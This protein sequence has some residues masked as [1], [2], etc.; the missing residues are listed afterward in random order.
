MS[1]AERYEGTKLCLCDERTERLWISVDAEIKDGKL[2]VSGQDLGEPCRRFW[3]SDE[4]EYWYS[5]DEENT[6][7]LL[8]LLSKDGTDP[9]EQLQKCFNGTTACRSLRAFCEAKGIAFQ[10]GNWIP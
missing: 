7:K 1:I 8:F 5:F 9:V 4:Y 2:I 6:E 3:G 10:F